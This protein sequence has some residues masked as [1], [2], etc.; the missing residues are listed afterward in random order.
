[1]K[2]EK[3][4]WEALFTIT[5]FLFWLFTFFLGIGIALS[6]GWNLFSKILV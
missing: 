4:E 5:G 1:M 2:Q 6:I 3:S